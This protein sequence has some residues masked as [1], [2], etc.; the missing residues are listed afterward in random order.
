MI[1]NVAYYEKIYFISDMI[2]RRPGV[3]KGN[4]LYWLKEEF[5]KANQ[6]ELDLILL[7]LM[8]RGFYVD[9][10]GCIYPP[11]SGK[12]EESD[13]R[14]FA[15]IAG[16]DEVDLGVLIELN[17]SKREIHSLRELS[18]IVV[19]RNWHNDEKEIKIRIQYL[20]LF[21]IIIREDNRLSVNWKIV[22]GVLL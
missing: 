10:G 2:S 9:V 8:D 18:R 20:F 21:K 11:H 5:P 4:L 7:E 15:V 12:E 17:N 13:L 19:S 22:E 6:Q 14:A 16:L 1:H 3:Y